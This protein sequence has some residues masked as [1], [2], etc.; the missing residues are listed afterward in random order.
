MFRSLQHA[1]SVITIF[2]SSKLPLSQK[3]LSILE[4][5]QGSTAAPSG[6]YRFTVDK[7]I[8]PPTPEQFAFFKQSLNTNPACKRAMKVAYP[9]INDNF[10]QELQNANFTNIFTPP[11]VVDWDHGLLAANENDLAKIINQFKG[12]IKD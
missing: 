8:Q 10:V 2:H 4:S 7:S 6:E 5:A 9:S 11:L 1:P 3:L 12:N